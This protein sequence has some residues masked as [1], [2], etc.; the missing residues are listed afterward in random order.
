MAKEADRIG[1]GI[2]QAPLEG[3]EDEI[4]A[5]HLQMHFYPP[6]LRSATVRK[7]LVGY[8]LMAEPQR[9]IT[10]EQAA[11]RLRDECGGEL[12]RKKL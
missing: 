12:Y 6:L 8:E 4:N 11:K 1:S 5:S 3:T 7:F 9:D 10:P 2:H